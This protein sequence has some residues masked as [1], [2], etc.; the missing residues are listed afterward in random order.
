MNPVTAEP[1]AQKPVLLLPTVTPEL[2]VLAQEVLYGLAEAAKTSPAP[3]L[4]TGPAHNLVSIGRSPLV[5]LGWTADHEES[6]RRAGEA[7][8]SVALRGSPA[9]VAKFQLSLS[10]AHAPATEDPSEVHSDVRL[11]A[12]VEPFA[13]RLGPDGKPNGRRE[14]ERARRWGAR[15]YAQWRTALEQQVPAEPK[16]DST[17]AVSPRAV[18]WCGAME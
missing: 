5:I 7:L 9:Y 12:P 2:E 6:R 14:L 4:V 16:A 1:T 11:L 13:I 18:S 15:M 8:A 10:G 17:N 3:I